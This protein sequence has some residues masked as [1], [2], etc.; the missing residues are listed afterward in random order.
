MNYLS[1]NYRKRALKR[2]ATLRRK[3]AHMRTSSASY[4]TPPDGRALTQAQLGLVIFLI[5]T[6]I[7]AGR[8]APYILQGNALLPDLLEKLIDAWMWA[9]LTPVLM[10]VDRQ[11]TRLDANV[12]RQVAVLIALSAP[13]SAAH[14]YLTAA[15]QYPFPSIS[16]SPFRSPEYTVHYFVGGWVTYVGMAGVLMAVK[17]YRRFVTSRLELERMEKRLL[18]SR[19]NALRLQLEPHFLFNALNAIS[20]EVGSNQQ[21]ARDMI[22]NLGELLR[23]SLAFG[24]T[25]EIP[26]SQELQLLEHYLAIQRVRFCD[27]I[28][29]ERHVEPE[30]TQAVVPCM[31]LQPLVEN[32]I[33][34]GIEGRLSGGLVAVSARRAG[35]RVEIKVEDNG[36][37]LPPGWRMESSA[38]LGIKL[39]RERLAALYHE[40]V[41]R[42]FT[43][44]RR[45]GGGTEVIVSLP[46]QTTRDKSHVAAPV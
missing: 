4:D 3:D 7:G 35:D 8:S 15:A 42:L 29:I 31:L 17:Y 12:Y 22:G 11:L 28:R 34:H 16:W 32:A 5:W 9:L 36:V 23:H 38:G 25:I 14:L 39:T 27:R 30:A 37:G 1:S 20:S 26:L 18:E 19:L 46:L 21:V 40:E 33:R 45:E 2:N 44:R 41:E 43:V 13:F 10:Y 24:D 6:A